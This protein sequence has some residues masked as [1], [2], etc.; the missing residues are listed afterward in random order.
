MLIG[1]MVYYSFIS[2]NWFS[3]LWKYYD[4]WLNSN[5][6]SFLEEVLLRRRMF[7]G[8]AR[9]SKKAGDNGVSMLVLL[10]GFTRENWR[11]TTRELQM[12]LLELLKLKLI[13]PFSHL[14]IIFF[15]SVILVVIILQ[16]ISPFFLYYKLKSIIYIYPL[17][18]YFSV[19]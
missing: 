11:T 12:E 3:M 9:I 1:V 16:P 18:S 5:I 19:L 14:I 7:F 8:L 10:R 6:V 17:L 2:F 15:L 4:N 13:T